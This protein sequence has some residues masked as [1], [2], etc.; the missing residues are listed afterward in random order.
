MEFLIFLIAFALYFVPA[1]VA[2]KRN[3]RNQGAIFALNL[4]LGW[5]FL[6]WV[7]SLVW[8]LTDNIEK[9]EEVASNPESQQ[10]N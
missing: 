2:G 3:H 4:L 9:K 1:V 5:T 7:L 6:F 10:Q 8:A